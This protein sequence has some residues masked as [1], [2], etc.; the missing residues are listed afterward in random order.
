MCISLIHLG[1][2]H[3]SRLRLTIFPFLVLAATTAIVIAFI[4][5][6]IVKPLYKQ[7][8]EFDGQL[9]RKELWMNK[10]ALPTVLEDRALRFKLQK[11]IIDSENSIRSTLTQGF[12]GLLLFCT[13]YISWKT[14][15]ATN[16][17]QV[18]E[19]FSKAV[20]Q[21]GNENIHVRLGGIYSL[22]QIAKDS[23]E[24]YYRQVIESL[25]SYLRERAPYVPLL[26]EAQR[27]SEATSESVGVDTIEK[28]FRNV[29]D[30]KTDI[31]AVISVLGRRRYS[32]GRG[33][34]F[35]LDFRAVDL[36]QIEFPTGSNFN[37][38]DFTGSNLNRSILSGVS[39]ASVRFN[40]ANLVGIT[41][42]ETS[43]DHS[44]MNS[45]KLSYAK[46]QGSSFRCVELNHADLTKVGAEMT[47][48]SNADMSNAKLVKARFTGA[49]L[50]DAIFIET[51]LTNA[52]LTDSC[53]SGL[54]VLADLRRCRGLTSDQLRSAN[55]NESTISLGLNDQQ[56]R[57]LLDDE[58]PP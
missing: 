54:K 49:S 53:I 41:A 40:H 34:D 6:I 58:Q 36:T 15:R 20:E 5:P 1:I 46:L 13:A 44:T 43:F 55:L 38:S 23:E 19:R 29:P 18:A 17:K 8:L 35:H 45:A 31:Q 7:L 2:M 24:R 51:D 4:P 27:V 56:K 57:L 21:L 52:D 50:R 14:L 22:E 16:E 11:D 9:K 26:P 47:I 37:G 42:K 10:R 12:G 32:F 28:L 25:T 30:L 48:F 33:E 39:F 3:L